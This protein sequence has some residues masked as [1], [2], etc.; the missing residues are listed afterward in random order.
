M[1]APVKVVT[2]PADSSATSTYRPHLDGLR[3]VAVY[4]VV[5][6]HARAD[7]FGGG[8]IGV[9]V[10][11]VLSGYL[12]TQLLL[13]DIDQRGSID[14]RRFYA[15]R[16][17][18]LMPAAAVVLV[19]TILVFGVIA[20]PAE[21]L[22]AKGGLRAASLYFANWF[23]IGESKDYFAADVNGS[24]VLHFWSL[25]VEEQYY[26]AWPLLLGGMHLLTRRMGPRQRRAVFVIVAA[27]A[28]A[29]L[30]AAI[31]IARTDLNRAYYGT[32]TRAYQLLAGG[33]LALAPG[34]A[35]RLRRASTA[36][37][38]GL[39]F[40]PVGALLAIV[41]AGT[42]LLDV[43]A[44]T[45]GMIA[46][47]ATAALILSLEVTPGR[48]GALL[49]L[50][51][52]V[53]LGR[54]SYGTYLWH[55]IVIL[56]MTATLDVGPV[57]TSAA[58]RTVATALA[59]LSY[60]LLEMP[61]RQSPWL[62]R[63]RLPVIAVGLATSAMIGLVV[64]P[65][66]L[67]PDTGPA[68]AAAAKTITGLTRITEEVDWRAADADHAPYE[69]CRADDLAACTI[70]EDGDLRVLLIGDSNATMY[71]PMF[72]A[73]AKQRH[74][75]LYAAVSPG[76]YWM[77]GIQ[78]TDPIYDEPCRTL[79]HEWYDTIV[80][81]LDPDLIFVVNRIVDSPLG[82]TPI[83][84]EEIGPLTEDSQQLVD[85]YRRRVT[86]TVED[87]RAQSRKVVIVEPV[88]VSAIDPDTLQCLSQATYLEECRFVTPVAPTATE[89]IYRE[90]DEA[91]GQVWSL[92]VDRLMCPFLPIC[93][94]VV[95]GL[96]VR[97]DHA[98]ITQR[99]AA[100][101]MPAFEAALEENGI[102]PPAD[103]P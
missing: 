81:E 10:F 53:Y 17:R 63:R 29:S 77:A 23:F 5:A 57:A 44:I 88:P 68:E 102:I 71:L 15:R 93:D 9:D 19:L 65:S 1:A 38:Q 45:R 22:D 21:L 50:R 6:F 85:A 49:S 30:V 28:A 24:P 12:V 40:V 13:R 84:D 78:R 103:K 25:S 16:F 2:E 76:C 33:L 101:L 42:T 47:A 75:A 74:F 7:R 46:T 87:L 99:F 92:N 62:D 89:L 80:P 27:A 48:V 8:F 54:I 64:A 58:K 94:P 66:L 20:S 69:I 86:A 100:S 52:V 4:L 98:H 82:A 41:V 61:V 90:A 70:V 3:A 95:N 14:F 26:V 31:W 37:R 97:W 72:E 56:V 18:R 67:D 60:Q 51:P 39:R 55:W 73:L 36:L 43:G 35:V 59:S 96:I 34:I 83:K 32:D 79:Q 91:D 11:F